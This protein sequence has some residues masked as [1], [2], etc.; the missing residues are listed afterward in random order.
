MKKLIILLLVLFSITSYAQTYDIPVSSGQR[1][2]I[3]RNSTNV[4]QFPTAQSTDSIYR[5]QLTVIKKYVP[6]VNQIPVARAGNDITLLSP[7]NSTTL[8][9]S[10]ST[11][12]DGT[13]ATYKWTLVSGG[14][15]TLGN[16][17]A[18]L[19][20]LTNLSV[21]SYTFK[22]TVTDNKGA[23]ATDNVN[24]TVNGTQP[25]P[26]TTTGYKGFG[27]ITTG[28]NAFKNTPTHVTNL[29]AS[30]PGSLDE[31]IKSNRYIVF[32]VAGTIFGFRWDVGN[33]Q[34]GSYSNITIDGTTAPSPGITLD[35]TGRGGN[36]FGFEGS[37][38]HDII[39]KSIRAINAGN[40]NFHFDGGVS[41]IILDHCAAWGAGDGNLDITTN[42]K[43]VTAQYSIFGPGCQCNANGND[44]WA[45]NSLI[46]YGSGRIS[47]HH[48]I[49]YSRTP[50][51]VAER[52]PDVSNQSGTIPSP[53]ALDFVNN[54]VYNWGRQ[55]PDGTMGSGYGTS[56]NYGSYGNVRNSYYYTDNSAAV[57][58]NAVTESAY[59]E[60]KGTIFA[61][62]NI[63]GN[64]A[65]V[66][67]LTAKTPYVIDSQ[68]QIPEED[69]CTAF[70]KT[71]AQ[72][73]VRYNGQLVNA[74]E[75]R[76]VNII[77]ATHPGC[78]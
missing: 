37:G 77:K 20:S 64:G 36:T 50:T 30:G 49:F 17:N 13:I 4:V 62:G 28:G 40:D 25:P 63:S 44:R 74:E 32:D 70:T 33:V 35:N 67:D 24:V 21:G 3:R 2:Y 53:L 41:N 27:S 54:I 10:G 1:F 7:N 14:T 34:S 38:N 11:D 26:D 23:S 43:N 57:Y 45:G 78:Q 48:S 22:L 61:K 71:V 60:P 58:D 55:K 42:T 76:I 51:G 68:F 12:A 39:V 9:G 66:N 31:A 69:A 18:A 75:I 59:G 65:K 16:S 72:A 5:F 19:T 52:N 29:N 46:A 56:F 73:G 6:P 8:D 47:I 15:Y